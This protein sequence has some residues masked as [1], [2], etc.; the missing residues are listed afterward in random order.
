MER[1]IL[2]W[3]CCNKIAVVINLRSEHDERRAYA[4]SGKQAGLINSS[5]PFESWLTDSRVTDVP[6]CCVFVSRESL[7]FVAGKQTK[8]MGRGK[9]RW[10][11]RETWNRVEHSAVPCVKCMRWT[12]AAPIPVDT[13]SSLATCDA[14]ASPRTRDCGR[15]WRIPLVKTAFSWWM[16]LFESLATRP[17]LLCRQTQSFLFC[18][19]RRMVREYYTDEIWFCILNRKYGIIEFFSSVLNLQGNK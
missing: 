12:F 14:I 1:N 19:E 4:K 17:R 5:A 9:D 15:V 11:E 8:G 3:F 10:N 18:S 7:F 2:V 13:R 6:A 16:I